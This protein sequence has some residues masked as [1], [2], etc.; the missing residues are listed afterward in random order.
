MQSKVPKV[1]ECFREK[2][3]E[4]EYRNKQTF[5]VSGSKG[6]RYCSEIDLCGICG[7]RVMT[8]ACKSQL[9][10]KDIVCPQNIE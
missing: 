8:R 5:M 2:K 4:S 1:E 6:K 9:S 3:T 10:I 7:K